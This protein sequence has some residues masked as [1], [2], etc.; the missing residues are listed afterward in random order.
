M[1]V[2]PEQVGLSAE[3]LARIT[4]HLQSKYVEP[5]KIMG[6]STLVA[7]HGE[8]V[9][10]SDLGKMD[11]ERDKDMEADTIFRIYSMSK[12][13]TSVALMML[14]ERG[15]FQLA[16]P[17]Y[18]YIPQW[19]N[20]EVYVAGEYPDFQTRPADRPMTIRDLLSHQAGLTY[21]FEGPEQS[22]RYCLP[23]TESAENG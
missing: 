9:Y 22:P 21:G 13:I 20:L 12:P 19:R 3:R 23:K 14:Y 6:F 15:M 2:K 7:R 4:E 18:K 5:R 8:V 11:L 1:T 10:R 16:D 17:V